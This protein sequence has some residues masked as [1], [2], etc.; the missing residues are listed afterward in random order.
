M[1]IILPSRKEK[2]IEGKA[3]PGKEAT[4]THASQ[5]RGVLVFFVC[6]A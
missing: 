2:S 3:V 5:E 1:L 4:V 6:V